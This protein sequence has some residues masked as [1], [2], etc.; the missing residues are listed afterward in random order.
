MS[1][2]KMILVVRTKK[3]KEK[4]EGRK[5]GERKKGGRKINYQE[6]RE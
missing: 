1:A 2:T 5:K 6:E 4:T 3:R